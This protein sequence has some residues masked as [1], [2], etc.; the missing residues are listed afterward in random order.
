MATVAILRISRL[1]ALIDHPRTGDAERAAAQRMLSRILRNSVRDV[2]GERDYG[3]RYG[4]GGRHASLSRIAEM[5]RDDI[6]LARS[7]FAAPGLRG[8]VAECDPIADAPAEIIYSVATPHDCSIVISIDN[9]PRSWGWVSG[10]G[11][12]TI[13]P[14]LRALGDALADIL[15]SYN[16]DGPDIGKRFFGQVRAQGETLRW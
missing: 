5:V 9:I 15:D 2:S 10:D 14:A 7:A 4:R 3:A 11:V 12:E 13:S 1:R 16:H 8:D 6:A